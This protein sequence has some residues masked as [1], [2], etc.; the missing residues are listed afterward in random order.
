[1]KLIKK[2]IDRHDVGFVKL[3]P[4]EPEDMWHLYNIIV[5]GDIITASTVRKV[6]RYTA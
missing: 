4:E 5:V 2:S 6:H 1:M 3:Q